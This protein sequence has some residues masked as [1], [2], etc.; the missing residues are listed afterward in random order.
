MKS[1]RILIWL[2][3]VILTV[4]AIFHQTGYSTVVR[5]TS[6]AGVTEFLRSVGQG[7]WLYATYHWLFIAALGV[8]VSLF[9]SRA[10]VIVLLMSAAVVTGDALL[11]YAFV[12]PFIGELLLLVAALSYALGAILQVRTRS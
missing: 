3:S 7:L 6:A 11:L 5:D 8:V 2:G 1:S 9:P 4:T 12:G 10:S